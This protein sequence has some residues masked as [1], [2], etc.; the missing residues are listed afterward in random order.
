MWRACAYVN[1][2]TNLDKNGLSFFIE[3]KVVIIENPLFFLLAHKSAISEY[4]EHH[5][6]Q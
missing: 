2:Y 1:N 4:I 5:E 3:K 6:N